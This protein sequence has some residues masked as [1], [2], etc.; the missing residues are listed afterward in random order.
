MN[1]PHGAT[2]GESNDDPASGDRWNWTLGQQQYN[3]LKQTLENSNAKYKSMFAHH[4]LGGT[5]NYV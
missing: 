1:N 5:Q 3:W 4:M 2:A